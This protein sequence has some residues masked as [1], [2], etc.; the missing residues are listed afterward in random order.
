M[1]INSDTL[2]IYFIYNFCSLIFSGDAHLNFMSDLGVSSYAVLLRPA[3]MSHIHNVEHSIYNP[4][5]HITVTIPI[6]QCPVA[7][8]HVIPLR[9]AIPY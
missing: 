7:V 3:S 4:Q 9:Q 6:A 1:L 8:F 5:P 2:N